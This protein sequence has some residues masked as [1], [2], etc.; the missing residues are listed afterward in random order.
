MRGTY[1]YK[2]VFLHASLLLCRYDAACVDDNI[3]SR[4]EKPKTQEGNKSF[5]PEL[6]KSSVFRDFPYISVYFTYSYFEYATIG[7]LNKSSV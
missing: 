5:V 3:T 4:V 1:I 6:K 7:F 2:E